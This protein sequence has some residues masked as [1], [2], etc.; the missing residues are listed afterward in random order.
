[1]E[2]DSRALYFNMNISK[3]EV[4][5]KLK[6]MIFGLSLASVLLVAPVFAASA[7][8]SGK[9]ISIRIVNFK[10]CVSK[11]KAGKTEEASFEELKKQMEA[12]LSEKDKGLNE[13]ADKF[14]DP[15]Y[16]DSLSA[17]A[18]TELKR[19]FRALSQE[20]QQQQQEFYQQLSQTNMKVIQKLTDMAT[21]AAE[22]VAKRD[23]IQLIL[24]EAETFFYAPE[25]DITDEV[26][27]ILDEIYEKESKEPTAASSKLDR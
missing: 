18:E 26:V 19:K 24:S 12:V 9:P 20:V 22:T 5:K 21:K 3:G 13:I 16:I 1:M 2:E 17:E 4:M 14:E 8:L 10:E 11:S 27:K 15:D 6:N 25:L 7:D 23:K